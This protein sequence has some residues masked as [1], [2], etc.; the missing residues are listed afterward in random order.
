MKRCDEKRRQFDA[1][2]H[3]TMTPHDKTT[4]RVTRE[5][6]NCRSTPSH[7]RRRHS[8]Q[9]RA[10]MVCLVSTLSHMTRTTN[11]NLKNAENITF[12]FSGDQLVHGSSFGVRIK[13][14]Q[15][16]DVFGRG[17]YNNKRIDFLVIFRIHAVIGWA[18]DALRLP[19][20][21]LR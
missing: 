8:R 17:P 21:M 16:Y 10:E 4:R 2:V 6:S 14:T 19:M 3:P 9:V 11:R 5:P 12:V 13:S 15:A 18:N 1:P 7:I 20:V